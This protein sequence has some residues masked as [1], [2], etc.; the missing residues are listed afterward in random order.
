MERKNYANFHFIQKGLKLKDTKDDPLDNIQVPQSTKNMLRSLNEKHQKQ[1]NE[2]K[3]IDNGNDDLQEVWL[4]LFLFFSNTKP[5]IFG[6]L[7]TCFSII[8]SLLMQV[9]KPQVK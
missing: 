6:Y 4:L 1:K 7:L 8:D 5:F 2:R 9:V 3:E